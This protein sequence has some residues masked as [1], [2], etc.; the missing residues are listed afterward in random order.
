M[1]RHQLNSD[2]ALR[3]LCL[4]GHEFEGHKKSPKAPRP[5]NAI[6]NVLLMSRFQ[7]AAADAAQ[8]NNRGFETAL[9]AVLIIELIRINSGPEILRGCFFD[10]LLI[11]S[12]GIG[13][14]AQ[15]NN[16]QSKCQERGDL[17]FGGP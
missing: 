11:A 6:S 3:L 8:Q 9:R 16:R 7:K 10:W 12:G 15:L 4:K 14:R 5:L 13:L 17:F 2:Q 1:C